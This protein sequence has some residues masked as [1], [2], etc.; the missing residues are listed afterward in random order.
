MP[1]DDRWLLPEGIEEVLPN[2]A[3]K[4][5]RMRRAL[6]DLFGSW[7]YELVMPPMI[8]FLDS[9]LTGLGQDL[10][11]QTFKL[12]DQLT[13]RLM[14]ARADM[15]P[16]VARID[17]HYLKRNGPVRLCYLGPVLHTRPSS[18]GGSREPL[19][20][21]AELFGHGGAEA[22]VE[23]LHLMAQTMKVMGLDDLHVDLGHVGIY[24]SMSTAFGVH[25]QL[26]MDLFD[27]LLRKSTP[28]IAGVLAGSDLP[29]HAR[30][31]FAA[32]IDLNGD[33]QVLQRARALLAAGGEAVGAALSNLEQVASLA[34]RLVPSV[35]WHFDLAELRGYRYHTGAV[36]AAYIPGHGQAIAHGGRYDSIGRAFGFARPATGFSTDLRTLL[37]LCPD[38]QTQ[39][40]CVLAPFGD[41]TALWEA[42]G[43]LRAQGEC[44]LVALPDCD[45]AELRQRCDRVLLERQGRW[46][47]EVL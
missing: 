42:I 27:A 47:V 37:R 21:G 44:V 25:G 7:G 22:D 24:R 28:D 13:G 20:L 9:L 23:I 17:A 18:F 12:T 43:A 3:Y 6:L 32:L 10:D 46:V 8:E 11:L 1:V 19:Q 39:R 41:D 2:E 14:G 4:L 29:E 35:K 30:A 38:Q 16:Q 5:E 45:E 31:M 36:F 15:T 34:A 40:P 33:A 26:E